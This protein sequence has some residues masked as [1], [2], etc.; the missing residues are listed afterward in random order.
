MRHTPE[1]HTMLI[2]VIAI[3]LIVFIVLLPIFLVSPPHDKVKAVVAA[4]TA[5]AMVL[6]K[7][8]HTPTSVV[9]VPID[10][11]PTTR[12][13]HV[14]MY[15]EQY[16]PQ[17]QQHRRTFIQNAV[18]NTVLQ[19]A[20]ITASGTLV[21][22]TETVN[23]GNDDDIIQIT[24]TDPSMK[25]GLQ[26]SDSIDDA[27]SSPSSSNGGRTVYV[28]RI[29]SPSVMN[30][31]I[32]K[33]MILLKYTNA[34]DVQELLLKK[35][36]YPITLLFQKSSNPISK[37]QPTFQIVKISST[38]SS[39]NNNDQQQQQQLQEQETQSLRQSSQRGDVLG[40]IYEARIDSPTGRIYDASYQRGTGL[41]PYQMVLGSGD[42]IIGVDQGLYDMCMNEI[43][44]IYIPSRLAYG[45]RG[46]K[47]FLIPPNSNLYWKVQ[48]I[49]ID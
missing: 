38:C 7:C 35:E 29:V 20:T 49:G 4:A 2:G 33:G 21:S 22:A 16:P 8:V 28:E 46:N 3:K 11:H 23:D 19:I 39:S 26:L 42:M 44:G 6:P 40:I 18:R 13:K 14:H 43:R 41:Q 48:L 5:A 34:K 12:T 15:T 45:T 9:S 47:T 10:S 31:K 1:S 25:L 30:T 36:S 27:K 17:Q 32:E 24:L 37:L